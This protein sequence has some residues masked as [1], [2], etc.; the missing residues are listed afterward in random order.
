MKLWKCS[1]CSDEAVCDVQ[2][3]ERFE[4]TTTVETSHEFKETHFW[5]CLTPQGWPIPYSCSPWPDAAMK[6]A[7][8]GTS[9][10]LENLKS[11]GFKAARLLVRK[12]VRKRKRKAKA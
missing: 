2:P 11:A 5:F 9:R 7:A 10:S 6:A 4:R 8:R 1:Q 12:P 3:S